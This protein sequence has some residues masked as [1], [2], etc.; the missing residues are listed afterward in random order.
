MSSEFTGFVNPKENWSKLPHDLIDALPMVETIGEMKVI[1]YVL[2]HTWGFQEFGDD[3][4]K[5][6]TFDEFMHGR[7]QKDRTRMDNGTGLT[8]PTLRDG[9][10]R[11]VEHGFIKV[12]TDDRDLARVKK[13]YSLKMKLQC[14]GVKKLS[15]ANNQGERNPNPEVKNLSLYPKESLP[16]SEKDTLERYSGK[17]L[18]PAPNSD[19]TSNPVAAEKPV[20]KNA[21]EN[22]EE[23][24]EFENFSEAITT[25]LMET[26]LELKAGS[27]PAPAAVAPAAPAL[28][29]KNTAVSKETALQPPLL[30]GTALKSKAGS[31]PAPAALSKKD[32]ALLKELGL[33][34]GAHTL[35]QR[36]FGA[37]AN[38]LGWSPKLLNGRLGNLASQYINSGY[39][40]EQITEFYGEGGL[41]YQKDWRGKL[42]QPPNEKCIGETIDKFIS[43][44]AKAKAK[45]TNSKKSYP[46]EWAEQRWP[47]LLPE[48]RDQML[49]VYGSKEKAIQAIMEGSIYCGEPESQ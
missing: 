42:G 7:K 16:R 33:E 25:L 10:A 41:W 24:E 22:F 9:I 4:K 5:R 35:Q 11:A 44:K 26:A 14:P 45:D 34:P 40:P 46:R 1:L 32:A 49:A 31:P 17:K 48:F 28:S 3:V 39:T 18:L 21:T 30:K 29:K 20:E 2:R 36:M 37:L 13:F 43:D 6:I 23:F 27:P 47:V 12:E 38:V 15:P 19:S 8:E